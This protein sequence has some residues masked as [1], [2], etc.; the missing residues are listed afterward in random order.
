MKT[1][2]SNTIQEKIERMSD[3]NESTAKLTAIQNVIRNK[4]KK[5]HLNRLERENDVN[6]T[7]NKSKQHSSAIKSSLTTMIPAIKTIKAGR[8]IEM[9]YPIDPNDLCTQLRLLINASI[10]GKVNRTCE[11]N[12]IIAKL[13]E[14]EIIV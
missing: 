2:N 4:F 1:D 7:L 5:A 9:Q 13:H 11:I 10:A 12:S 6:H 3:S 14:L 8:N